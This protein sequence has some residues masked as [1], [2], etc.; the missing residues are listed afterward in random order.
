MELL[1]DTTYKSMDMTNAKMKM[2]VTPMMAASTLLVITACTFPDPSRVEADFGNSVR[3][4]VA[5]QIYDPA[6]A[7]DPEL[8]GPDELAGDVAAASVANYEAA[9]R[10]ARRDRGR[11]PNSPLPVV[12]TVSETPE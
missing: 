7:S 2:L 1:L 3:N 4:M 6:I 9:S 11:T 5:E 12:G 8:F 10:E